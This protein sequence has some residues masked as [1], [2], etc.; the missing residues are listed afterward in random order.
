MGDVKLR[1]FNYISVSAVAGLFNNYFVG[2]H[3]SPRAEVFSLSFD[4]AD[5]VGA[6]DLLRCTFDP[7][8][9]YVQT[10]FNT[11]EKSFIC[12]IT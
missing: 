4:D 9:S 7:L 8:Y 12:L 11:K 6:A 2:A 1:V 3:I 5:D 10:V